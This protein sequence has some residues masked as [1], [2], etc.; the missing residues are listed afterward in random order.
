[1]TK[2]IKR[3]EV[4]LG[5]AYV[6]ITPIPAWKILGFSGPDKILH[7]GPDPAAIYL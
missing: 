5:E 1:M 6:F 3:E 7:L 4:A 2:A